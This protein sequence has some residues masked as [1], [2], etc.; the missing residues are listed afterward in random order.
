MAIEKIIDQA[1]QV[2]DAIKGVDLKGVL[3]HEP[4]AVAHLEA[5]LALLNSDQPSANLEASESLE[6]VEVEESRDAML[7]R[8]GQMLSA[9]KAEGFD[10]R[11]GKVYNSASE[12]RTL[13]FRKVPHR[14]ELPSFDMVVAADYAPSAGLHGIFIGAK[15]VYSAV[16]PSPMEQNNWKV[17]K[18]RGYDSDDEMIEIVT[19]LSAGFD[20]P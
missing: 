16:L 20:L 7:M 2:V 14:K 1:G 15:H 8:H 4:E 19:L 17:L 11:L 10:G 3:A 9:L 13:E 12:D 18:S 6:A 5:V